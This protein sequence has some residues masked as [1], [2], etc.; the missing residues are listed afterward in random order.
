MTSKSLRRIIAVLMA[1]TMVF[2]MSTSVFAAD[3]GVNVKV[4]MGGETYIEDTI[5][6]ADIEGYTNG[7]AHLYSMEGASSDVPSIGY[8]ATDALYCV[9]AKANGKLPDA[10]QV[11]IGWDNNPK[12]GQP[13]AYFTVYDGASADA[14]SYYYVGMKSN[15]EYEYYWRGDTWNLYIDGQLADKYATSYALS[16]ISEVVFDY[17]TTRSENFTLDYYI[18]GCPNASEDPHN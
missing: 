18:E 17:N 1:M 4:Q 16:N 15:G 5:S 10:D 12:E 14:G 9:W 8:T 13:G 11:N 2:A 3:N 6:A 7:N